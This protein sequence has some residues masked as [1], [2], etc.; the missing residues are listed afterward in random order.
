MIN[1][2]T[3]TH[4][5]LCDVVNS[6]FDL[7]DW[8]IKRDLIIPENMNADRVRHYLTQWIEEGDEC[9]IL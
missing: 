7:I 5:E 2:D 6:D 8:W 4:K 9:A 1:I 3:A